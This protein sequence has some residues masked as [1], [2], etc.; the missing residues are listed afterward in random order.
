MNSQ[1]PSQK[2]LLEY[3]SKVEQTVM[4]LASFGISNNCQE[5]KKEIENAK[6]V[7]PVVGG[8]SAG[9]STLLNSFLGEKGEN[10]ILPTAI[11]AETSVPAEL[12]YATEPKMEI[13]KLKGGKEDF[14]NFADGFEYV[15]QQATEIDRVK[16]FLNN[17]NL[18]DIQPFILVD[19]PG[20]DSTVGQ[21]Q[22]AITNYM[23][24]AAHFIFVNNVEDGTIH[25]S[26]SQRLEQITNVYKK[27]FHFGLTKTDLKPSSEYKRNIRRR[28]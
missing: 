12:I 8:F 1:L 3:I 23:G 20:F 21:H 16:I 7:I 5:L 25:K 19:M 24:E 11:T 4:P 2:K 14:A 15:K 17:E 26:I 27:S 13:I 22:D 9:K 6:L 10:H 18:K 28:L